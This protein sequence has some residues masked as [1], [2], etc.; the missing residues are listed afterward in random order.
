MLISFSHI[1][2][3]QKV[4]FLS[5][6]S[7]PFMKPFVLINCFAEV[8]FAS[9][10]LSKYNIDFT[11]SRV[12]DMKGIDKKVLRSLPQALTA[13]SSANGGSVGEGMELKVQL[14]RLPSFAE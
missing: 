2:N 3:V 10:N 14:L 13:A 1:V 5:I 9:M 6:S 11:L 12:I 4:K 8:S 7:L